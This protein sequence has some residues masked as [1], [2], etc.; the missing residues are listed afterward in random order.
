MTIA[1]PPLRERPGDA[2]VLAQYF[3]NI[4]RTATTKAKR[5]S[6]EATAA[7]ERYEWQGNA[8]ELENKVKRAM[9]FADSDAVTESDLGLKPVQ[10]NAEEME[11]SDLKS[12]RESAESEAILRAL[13]HCD[14]KISKAAQVLGVSRPTLYDLIEKYGL[15]G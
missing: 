2:V 13:K 8:R 10:T 15:K 6:K 1:I 11:V 3:L 14:G 12:V 4:N 7:I 5:F 9:I